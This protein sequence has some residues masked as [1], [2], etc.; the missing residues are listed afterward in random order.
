M[1]E[2]I[3]SMASM[4]SILGWI[5]LALSPLAPTWADRIAGWLLPSVLAM[6]YVGLAVW[7]PPEDGGFGSLAEVGTLFSFP[8]ALLSGWIHF[9]AFDLVVGAW[10]CRVARRRKLQ[11]WLVLPCLPVVF[12]FGPAGL[13]MFAVVLAGA[14]SARRVRARRSH[15]LA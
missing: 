2:L 5:T 6:L 3:F 1:Y 4:I 14:E 9:L 7:A 8:G 12:L 15:R 10:V 11:F 13:L